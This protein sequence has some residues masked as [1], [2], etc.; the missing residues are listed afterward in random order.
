MRKYLLCMCMLAVA[1]SM[2]SAGSIAA[3]DSSD[4]YEAYFGFEEEE[5][6][7]AGP[8]TLQ[9]AIKEG[10]GY[11]IG[12]GGAHAAGRDVH[13]VRDGDT[14]WDISGHYYGD[15]WHWPQLWSYN[16]E[17]TNPH[18]IYPLDEIRLAPGAGGGP[19]AGGYAG[20]PLQPGPATAGELAGTEA[21]PAIVVPRRAWTPETVFLRDSGYLDKEALKTIGQIE[22]GNEEHMMLSPSDQV[23]I[24][25]EEKQNVRAG[26]QFTIFRRLQDWERHPD[27]EGELVRVQGLAVIRSYDRKTRVG[28]GVITEALEPIERGYLVAKLDRRFD[29]VQ[30]QRN[31]ANVVARIIATV[32]PRSLLSFQNVVFLDVGQGQGIKPG[33]RFFVVRKGDEWLEQSRDLTGDTRELG[34]IENAP[35]YDPDALPKE[36]V[37]ELRV[38][39]VRKDTTIALV[40]R[41]DTDLKHGDI[42]EMRKGF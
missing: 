14:L 1:F 17:I 37:A 40:T 19:G 22:S 15:P 9:Q 36:V 31:T 8:A 41:S 5:D 24:R 3:Q 28:R 2:P 42:A 33:N 11:R 7:E 16:P 34:S 35:P 18:W 39:K 25:F 6:E 21:A 12:Q 13:V 4:D 38:I 30:P 20:G 29:L 23:Y 26:D 27:E 10:R 32:R